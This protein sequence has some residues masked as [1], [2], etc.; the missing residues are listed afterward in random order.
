VHAVAAGVNPLG[1]NLWDLGRALDLLVEHPLVDPDRIGMVGLS[2][3]ATATLFLA[4]LD[5]RVQA[6][7]VSGYFS[8]WR[9]A[10]RVPWNLCGSQVLPAMLSEIEHAGLGALIAP[11][12][13]LVE[14][15]TDDLIFPV[16]GARREL[17]RVA[18]VYAAMGVGDRVEHDVFAGGHR[19]NGVQAYPFLARWIGAPEVRARPTQ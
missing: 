9:E 4:A 12:A 10:H 3:G 2:Y 7:V 14:T 15:G 11:R 8:E 6:A 5:P 13:L 19:W 16:D 1:Q 17:A 18:A